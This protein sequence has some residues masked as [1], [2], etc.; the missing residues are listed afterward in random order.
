MD[1]VSWREVYLTGAS[2][3]KKNAGDL[4]IGLVVGVDYR[5]LKP[6]ELGP[7]SYADFV[8]R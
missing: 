1:L 7:E 2:C 6:Y 3:S 5:E 8:M 4:G